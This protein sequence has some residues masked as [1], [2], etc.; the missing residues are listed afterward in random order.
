MP[1]DARGGQLPA[2]TCGVCKFAVQPDQAWL[3]TDQLGARDYLVA[4]DDAKARDDVSFR[5]SLGPSATWHIGHERCAPDEFGT[6]DV[7]LPGS[8]QEL[9]AWA[10]DTLLRPWVAG[11]DLIDFLAEA[12]A[13]SGRFTPHTALTQ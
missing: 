3:W 13:G 11:S 7:R 8:H 10:A 9:L 4:R 5:H 12:G 1:D 2:L 6:Y